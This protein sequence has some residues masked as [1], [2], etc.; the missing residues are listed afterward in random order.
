M[1]DGSLDDA[2]AAIEEW[3][4]AEMEQ[5]REDIWRELWE[6]E[7][8]SIPWDEWADLLDREARGYYDEWLE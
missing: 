8:Q 3:C 2:A 1:S 6:Q 4:R 5:I 7:N